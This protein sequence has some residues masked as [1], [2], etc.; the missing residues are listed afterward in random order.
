M[1]ESG[2]IEMSRLAIAALLLAVFTVSVGY[3]VVLP[4]L[5]HVVESL[6]PVTSFDAVGRHT[7]FLTSIYAG[8]PLLFAPLWGRLSDH[9][10]RRPILLIGLAGFGAT[11][12]VTTLAPDLWWLYA[13]RFLDGAFAAAILPAAQ[14]FIGDR[15]VSDAWRAQRFAWLG[16]ASIAGFFVGPMLGG[17]VLQAG[18]PVPDSMPA[19]QLLALPFLLSA[20]LALVGAGGILAIERGSA[21]PRLPPSRESTNRQRATGTHL[22]L[23]TGFVATG[24]AA[25]EVA[26]AL[27]GRALGMTPYQVGIMFAECSLIMFAVQALVFSPF[28]APSSTAKLI[29]PG[30]TIMG[31]SLLLVPYAEAFGTQLIVV[32]AVAA[33]AG[34]LIPTLTYWISLGAGGAQGAELGRQ[35]AVASFGQALGSAGGGLLLGANVAPYLGFLILAGLMLAAAAASLNLVRRL[36][37]ENSQPSMLQPRWKAIAPR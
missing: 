4:V 20:G 30:L 21:S 11:L 13:G 24:I 16:M 23:L 22:L 2:P 35:A 12:A 1:S 37:A 31:V 19:A 28:M 7:G 5:P 15:T 18:S 6:S 3:G 34:I 9:H 27:R 32:G 14:A 33:S 8:A 25:F 17:I 10:G 36:L 26:L 29:V